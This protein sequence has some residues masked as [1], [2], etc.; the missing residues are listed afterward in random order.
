MGDG[1]L[2]RLYYNSG[3]TGVKVLSNA[4]GVYQRPSI[5]LLTVGKLITIAII[6]YHSKMRPFGCPPGPLDLLDDV[7]SALTDEGAGLLS[8]DVARVTLDN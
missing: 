4:G 2:Y 3:T 7:A 5:S 6:C 8:V 1:C